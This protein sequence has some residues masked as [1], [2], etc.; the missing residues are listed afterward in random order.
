[1]PVA[2]ALILPGSP[3][4]GGVD[5]NAKCARAARRFASRPFTGAWI[6]TTLSSL[7]GLTLQG[8]P[9]TGA[10]IETR[11]APRP[12]AKAAGR[13]FT[14]A[15]IETSA[16]RSQPASSRV[17]PSRGRGS[18]HKRQY[19]GAPLQLSPLHGGVDRNSRISRASPRKRQRRPF[20]GAWIETW[21]DA[22]WNPIVGWSPL[23]G[24]VDRNSTAKSPP[25]NG[26][27]AP[28][29]GRGSKPTSGA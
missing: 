5:R 13:P 10:W 1:M 14:G 23:H 27:V 29:R 7:A 8:R 12:R 28:S 20:T 17:A 16:A 26:R 3:L 24:G 18:K 22:T 9:F 19:F 15:W 6:E 11:S 25:Q 21:T 2:P 4:H